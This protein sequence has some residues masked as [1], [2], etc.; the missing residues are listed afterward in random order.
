MVLVGWLGTAGVYFVLV[1]LCVAMHYAL[2]QLVEKLCLTSKRHRLIQF[3]Q[4]A[5]WARVRLVAYSGCGNL[6]YFLD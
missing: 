5:V 3:G 6:S 4:P 1:G 2:I